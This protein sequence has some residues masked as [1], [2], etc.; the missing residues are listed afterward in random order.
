[1]PLHSLNGMNTHYFCIAELPLCIQFEGAS[2]NT[3]SLLPSFSPFALSGE[4]DEKELLFKL[5]VND[6]LKTRTDRSLLRHFDTGNGDTAVYLLPDGGYEFVI[7]NIHGAACCLL[8][9]NKQFN[10]C[11]CALNGTQAMRSFGLNDA[12]MLIFAFAGSY[13]QTTLIHA[14]CVEQQGVAYPFIAQSGTGKSTHTSLWMKTIPG[15]TLLNDDNHVIRILADG[16]PYI[17]GSPWSGKTPCYRNI[18]ARLG[19]VTH[20]ERAKEN[21][22]ERLPVVKAF[23]SLLPACSSMKW[24]TTIYHH[25]C[26][27]VTRLIE[28]VPI[29]TIY[30]LPNDE[31]ALLCHHTL[32]Q[33]QQSYK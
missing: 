7:K 31:A 14:S 15:T 16:Q 17:Y 1:M 6:N 28:R 20:I 8:Q 9:A 23:A 26:D 24:D 32:N 27:I 4:V 3:I 22:M 19:A 12:L 25:L 29:Y 10:H 21:R 18:K 30:C 33:K 11:Q 2:N 5:T 13:H